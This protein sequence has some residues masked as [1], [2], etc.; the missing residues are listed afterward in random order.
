M[1]V[2]PAEEACSFLSGSWVIT[3]VQSATEL[4][5]DKVEALDILN[6]L[7]DSN[8]WV[9]RTV[10]FLLEAPPSPETLSLVILCITSVLFGYEEV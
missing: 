6:S 1:D 4:G 7:W 2:S 10:L 3:S 5:W 9:G 8:I